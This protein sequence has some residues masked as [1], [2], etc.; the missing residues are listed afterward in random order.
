MPVL[1]HS[2]FEVAIMIDLWWSRGRSCALPVH[3]FAAAEVAELA[4]SITAAVCWCRRG[5]RV[6]WLPAY[7]SSQAVCMFWGGGQV[8]IGRGF[9]GIRAAP[10]QA[11]DVSVGWWR[12]GRF[13]LAQ[14]LQRQL[15]TT[16]RNS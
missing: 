8:C 13:E 5:Q 12:G 3:P 11:Y 4:V 9:P 16:G 14:W 10:F 2:P 7:N 6:V 15:Q 1:Q